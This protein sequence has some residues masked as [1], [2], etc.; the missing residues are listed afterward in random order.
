MKQFFLSVMVL[1]VMCCVTSCKKESHK[2]DNDED[3]VPS[4]LMQTWKL[5]SVDGKAVVTDKTKILQII[6]SKSANVMERVSDGTTPVW[7]TMSSVIT[8]KSDTLKIIGSIDRPFT[9]VVLTYKI[10]EL[11]KDKLKMRLLSETVN[12]HLKPDNI[13]Q[14][15]AYEP[16]P[17]DIG[18]KIYGMWKATSSS[19]LNPFG[20]HFKNTGDYDY[21][22][23]DS[24]GE[25]EMK[26]DNEGFFWFY[27]NFVVLRYKNTND[28]S[29]DQKE[30]IEC[31]NVKIVE[32]TDPDNPKTMT[33]TALHE[34]GTTETI[35]FK[36]LGIF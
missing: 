36:F 35:P 3:K 8:Y 34:D 18:A 14:E 17:F 2:Y 10:L 27:G 31:W 9:R 15:L 6:D 11:T 7:Q 1:G 32:T 5:L 29:H 19:N 22:Y 12:N 13:G 28:G 20:L 25:S 21:Y 33:F 30:Y 26:T 24:L 4:E 23:Y 16:A